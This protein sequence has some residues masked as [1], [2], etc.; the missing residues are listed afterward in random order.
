MYVGDYSAV[1]AAGASVSA[2]EAVEDVYAGCSEESG[3]SDGACYVP[4]T[5]V[6]AAGD[7]DSV[8]WRFDV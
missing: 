1:A 6:A 3:Y 4:E 8:D 7:S 5:R 2:D